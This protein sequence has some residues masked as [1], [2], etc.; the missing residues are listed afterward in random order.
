VRIKY[1]LTD[2]S[3]YTT[4]AAWADI[5]KDGWLDL[6][7]ANG[8]DM[9]RQRVASYLYC[10]NTSIKV[11]DIFGK[12]VTVLFLRYSLLCSRDESGTPPLRSLRLN[13]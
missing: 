9:A 7:V 1:L 2:V 4:G 3:N 10:I 6:V 12:E 5:N 11:F 13:F 8:N